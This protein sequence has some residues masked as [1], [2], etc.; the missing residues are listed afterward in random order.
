MRYRE[1][2]DVSFVDMCKGYSMLMVAVQYRML[3]VAIRQANV[4]NFNALRM[5][6]PD[7]KSKLR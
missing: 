5:R 3:M 6:T 2:I 1:N 7:N 4:A